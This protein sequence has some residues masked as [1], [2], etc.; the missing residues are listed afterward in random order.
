M[1]NYKRERYQY[2]CGVRDISCRSRLSDQLCYSSIISPVSMH[3]NM[4][5]YNK[6]FCH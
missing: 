2:S 5:A 4:C 6:Q 1:E 3:I